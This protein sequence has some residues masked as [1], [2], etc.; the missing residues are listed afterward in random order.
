MSDQVITSADCNDHGFSVWVWKKPPGV[1][2]GNWK[3]LCNSSKASCRA[4]RPPRPQEPLDPGTLK[5]TPSVFN[6]RL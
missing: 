5:L 1:R 6:K 4:E 2:H 3:M